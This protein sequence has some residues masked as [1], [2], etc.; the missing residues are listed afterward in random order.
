M[1]ALA[2]NA[3]A[4]NPPPPGANAARAEPQW[5]LIGHTDGD[6]LP[7]RGLP[8]QVGRQPGL[9]VRIVHPTVSLVHAEIHQ[10]VGG[11]LVRDLGSRNGTFVNGQRL[12]Q[13]KAICT[14]DLVQ[15][16]AAVFRVSQQSQRDMS[17]TCQAE[18]VSDLALALAQFDKLIS[19]PVVV[20]VFQPIVAAEGGQIVAYE[21]LARSSLYGLDKPAQMFKAAE[22]FQMEAELSRLLRKAG[23]SVSCPQLRPHLF[24]NTHPAELADFK[25]M[26]VSLRE[27]R[28]AR[29]QQP[30]TLEVHEAA[31]VDISTMKMLRL[32]LDD[33]RMKLAYDD[34]GA[35]QARL[36]E[37]VEARP[38]YLK[39]D[40]KLICDIDSAGAHRVQ[41][42]ESLVRMSR[43]LGIVT[44]AEGVETAAEAETCRKV[45]FELLQG[46][47]YG[48]PVAELPTSNTVC[49]G[50]AMGAGIH[51][52]ETPKS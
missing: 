51:L 22:Y 52:Y 38:D 6:V 5:S 44:L 17:M 20:P 4:V 15:F 39:F 26:I 1:D 7:L 2:L 33:L 40:R 45:G 12:T 31:A 19:E 42:I 18:E 13:P 23:L 46:Y 28:L 21:A 32:V 48:K 10:Q 47:Y 36:N 41:L 24:L 50:P 3:H 14:G 27:I 37:L 43:Q 29:P 25:R 16:G 11:L 49:F 35:G 9:A 30:I 8:C 34:F